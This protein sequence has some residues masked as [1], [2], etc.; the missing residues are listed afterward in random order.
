MDL[1]NLGMI[2][3]QLAEAVEPLLHAGVELTPVIEASQ[4]A[5]ELRLI[6]EVRHH[7]DAAAKSPDATFHRIILPV[8]QICNLLGDGMGASN[9]QAVGGCLLGSVDEADQIPESLTG[10]PVQVCEAK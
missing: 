9:I 10:V 2:P 5:V 3:D 7:H 6:G 1:P 8:R 4:H